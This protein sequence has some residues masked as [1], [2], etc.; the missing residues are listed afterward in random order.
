MPPFSLALSAGGKEALHNLLLSMILLFINQHYRKTNKGK[1]E[2]K[3]QK[4]NTH[5]NKRKM[6]ALALPPFSFSKEYKSLM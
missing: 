5:K 1:Q 6:R 4:K 3:K 2:K